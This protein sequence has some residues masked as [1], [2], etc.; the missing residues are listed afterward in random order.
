VHKYLL[1][2][3]CLAYFSSGVAQD[4]LDFDKINIENG[5]SHISVLDII[6]DSKGFIWIG[7]QYGLNKYDGYSFTV[8]NFDVDDN[9][10]ISSDFILKIFEDSTGL[11]WIGTS[12]G[13]NSFNPLTN[14]FTRYLYDKSK[15]DSISNDHITSIAEDTFGYIWIGTAGGGV[16]RLNKQTNVFEHIQLDFKNDKKAYFITALLLDSEGFLW[17]TSGSARLRPSIENGGIFKVDTKSLKIE[18]IIPQIDTKTFDSVNSINSIFEDNEKNLWF[19]TLGQGLLKKDANS[20]EYTQLFTNKISNK[21]T[22][23][24]ITQD[25]SGDLWISTQPPLLNQTLMIM[26]LLPC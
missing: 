24:D 25:S 13:L 18:Q 5:L 11:L 23:L 3:I 12:N 14:K 10:S 9:S 16:N 7:T 21:N 17:V 8:F 6:Q 15:Q 1:I 2:G 26:T 19:G 4:R 20:S 22:I